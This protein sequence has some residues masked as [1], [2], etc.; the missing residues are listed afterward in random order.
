MCALGCVKTMPAACQTNSVIM[1]GGVLSC[2]SLSG[3]AAGLLPVNRRVAVVTESQTSRGASP[4]CFRATM[5]FASG[6]SDPLRFA[7]PSACTLAALNNLCHRS[8]QR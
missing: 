3:S 8:L 6:H 7:S 4:W 1:K 5:M 2:C